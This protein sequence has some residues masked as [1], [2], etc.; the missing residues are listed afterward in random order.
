MERADSFWEAQ[1]RWN[2]FSI[3]QR[4]RGTRVLL[5]LGRHKETPASFRDDTEGLKE[6]IKVQFSEA[7]NEWSFLIRSWETQD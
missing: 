1:V 5:F 7:M 4:C 2:S 6:S 3:T